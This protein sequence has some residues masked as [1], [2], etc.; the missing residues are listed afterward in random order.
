MATINYVLEDT[1]EVKN[2]NLDEINKIIKKIESIISIESMCGYKSAS[3]DLGYNINVYDH[4]IIN[5]LLSYF[6]KQNIYIEIPGYRDTRCDIIVYWDSYTKN[7]IK[8]IKEY[9]SEENF[10]KNVISIT[11]N[12]LQ[13]HSRFFAAVANI[14]YNIR[15]YIEEFGLIYKGK[16]KYLTNELD[17]Y[18]NEIDFIVNIGMSSMIDQNDPVYE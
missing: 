14:I 10:M 13:N 16:I 17:Y 6:Y 5:E 8:Y 2:S 11:S 7:A 1:L 3:I 18:G 12:N 4:D 15:W 9:L